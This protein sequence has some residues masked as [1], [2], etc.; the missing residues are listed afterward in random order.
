MLLNNFQNLCT[1]GNCLSAS[2]ISVSVKCMYTCPI[3][4]ASTQSLLSMY[5]PW[6]YTMWSLTDLVSLYKKKLWYIGIGASWFP[7]CEIPDK[8]CESLRCSMYMYIGQILYPI[9]FTHFFFTW[10]KYAWQGQAVLFWVSQAPMDPSGK[11][12][13]DLSWPCG[14]LISDDLNGPS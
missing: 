14:W 7:F 1:S 5:L 4:H 2:N 6:H 11:Q 8:N 3:N 9:N 12:W 13:V 10:T